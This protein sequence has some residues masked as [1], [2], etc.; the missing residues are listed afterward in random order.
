MILLYNRLL[1]KRFLLYKNNLTPLKY[2][3]I[4]YIILFKALSAGCIIYVVVFE[5]LQRERA[6]L[7]RPKIVQFLALITGFVTMMTVD[8]LSKLGLS[9][10]NTVNQTSS[11]ENVLM[12]R[13]DRKSHFRHCLCFCTTD[14]WSSLAYESAEQ[15]PKHCLT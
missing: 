4:K 6:K 15:K 12:C 13:A 11:R 14:C 1:Y 7:I 10:C 5:V 9:R 2:L 3:H 8:L